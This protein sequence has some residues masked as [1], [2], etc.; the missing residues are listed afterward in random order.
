MNGRTFLKLGALCLLLTVVLSGLG[1]AQTR[2]L[3]VTDGDD[4]YTGVN[5]TNNPAGSGPKRTFEGAYAAF[6]S[7][8]T[9]RVA[10]GVYN[11]DQSG[12]GGGNDANG[13][14]LVGAKSMTFIIES[15]NLGNAVNLGGAGTFV[16]DVG[17]GNT[18][19][20]TP[21][22]PGTNTLGLGSAVAGITLTSG[23]MDVTGFGTTGFTVPATATAITRTGGA[24]T[25]TPSYAG[26][27]YTVLYNGA[28][29][30]TAGGEIPPT[31]ST[32]TL[33]K[34]SGSI[35]FNN[36][37]TFS[38]SGGGLSGTTAFSATFNGQVTLTTA[39]AAASATIVKGAATGAST[40]SFVGG[41]RVVSRAA[42]NGTPVSNASS[43]TLSV[44]GAVSI[45]QASTGAFADAVH[46]SLF[47]NSSTGTLSLT[48]GI[49]E[50]STTSPPY[51]TAAP[52]VLNVENTSTGTL[53][54]GG[55]SATTV[56]GFLT[57]SGGGT[58][59]IA[60]AVTV[61]GVLTNSA[62][63]ILALGTNT[64][65]LSGAGPHSNAGTI[66]S[67]GI[68]SGLLNF[69][70]T[71][72]KSMTGAGALPNVQNP[73]AGLLT[74][75]STTIVG[76]LSNTSSGGITAAS[77]TS[78]SGSIS[79]SGSGTITLAA[80]TT[81]GGA[82]TLGSSGGITFGA[83]TGLS[84][85]GA[86]S[87]TG[88]GTLTT[89]PG[90]LLAN[91]TVSISLGTFLMGGTVT[92][93]G[94]FTQTS[95]TLSFGIG[96]NLLDLKAD[97]MRVT[98]TVTSTDALPNGTPGSGTLRFSKGGSQ[99]FSGGANMT[100]WNFSVSAV[101]TGVTF[102]NGSIIVNRN[103]VIEANT[104]V[105][106]TTYNIR[107]VG[108][109]VGG[110]PP[111]FTHGGQY[112][113]TGGGGI[114]FENPDGGGGP[115]EIE[116]TIGGTGVYSNVEVRLADEYDFVNVAAGTIVTWSGRLTLTRGTI[117]TL[118]GTQL[119][120][121][122]FF[123]TP[124]IH[125]NLQDGPLAAIGDDDGAPDGKSIAVAGGLFNATGF[126]YHLEY[127]GALNAD[128]PVGTEF[129]S[130]ATT[131]VIDL[132]ISTTQGPGAG[133]PFGVDL[134]GAS[135]FRFSGNL[136]VVAGAILGMPVGFTSQ[137]ISNGSSVTH[138]VLGRIARGPGGTGVFRIDGTGVTINGPST[139]SV[140]PV[141]GVASGRITETLISLGASVTV[142][143][144]RHFTDGVTNLGTLNL[145]L[146]TI[147][148][149]AIDPGTTGTISAGTS[150]SGNAYTQ[151]STLNL[152]ANVTMAGPV[153]HSD[154]DINLFNY[155]LTAT[156]TSY[157]RAAVATAVY[158][159]APT[160]TTNGFLVLALTGAATF[161]FNGGTVPRL[162]VAASVTF[163]SSAEVTDR[164]RHTAGVVALATFNLT[165][166]GAVWSQEITGAV[167]TATTGNVAV[168]GPATTLSVGSAGVT[169]PNVTVA[170]TSATFTIVST[171]ATPTTLTISTLLT[172]TSGTIA[173]GSNDIA[174]TNAGNAYT[175]VAGSVT[176]TSSTALLTSIGEFVFGT[177]GQTITLTNSGLTIPNVRVVAGGVSFTPATGTTTMTITDRLTFGVGGTG[178]WGAIASTT[179][180]ASRLTV[181]SGAWI[182]RQGAG[183][184]S[185]APVFAGS[186]SLAY[187][188][189]GGYG[190][191]VEL[192]TSTTALLNLYISPAMSFPQGGAAPV[193]G[194]GGTITF[195]AAATATPVVVNGTLTLA[196][197]TL[198]Y[199]ATRP[200]QIAN[201]ATVR[202]E[203]NAVVGARGIISAGSANL[204][205]LGTY[206]L[207]YWCD[208][209][210]GGYASSGKEWIQGA[211][212]NL[213]VRMG[214]PIFAAAATNDVL[215]LHANRTV[216]NFT[217]NCGTGV[218]GLDL[219]DITDTF[220]S[221]LTVTGTTTLTMGTIYNGPVPQPPGVA[222][223]AAVLDVQG[224]VTI[225]AAAAFGPGSNLQF[226][227]TANQ[228]VTFPGP[229]VL[230]NVALNKTTGTSPVPSI[231]LIGPAAGSTVTVANIDFINGILI[232]GNNTVVLPTVVQ[233]FT[234][235]VAVGD[236]SHVVGNVRKNPGAFF[237]GRLEYPLGSAASPPRYRP[238]AIIFLLGNPLITAVGLTFSYVD[239]APA[240]PYLGF[241]IDAGSFIRLTGPA[242]FY[243]Q[244]LTTIGLNPSQTFD[245]ELTA[246]GYSTYT[247]GSFGINQLR[248][249]RRFGVNLNTNT[250]L[251]Q[252]GSNYSNFIADAQGTPTVR[253]IGSSGGIEPP[254]S[255]FTLG[256]GFITDVEIAKPG[257][258]SEYQLAQN[259]P[260]PFNPT[261]QINFDLPKQS[262]V[263]LEIYDMLGQ[264]VRTLING[265]TMEP[266]YYN[267]SWNGTNQ[268]G[269]TVS[270]GVY[271]YRIVA[272]KFMSLK[273]MMFM[274]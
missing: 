222:Y 111:S 242:P 266:G 91:N 32:L 253:V 49:T 247:S 271:F 201:G 189:T 171:G 144:I 195:T 212:A 101:G 198:A 164:Y 263:T 53:V 7:G 137:L 65:T 250:F 213:F 264:K 19:T 14:Q 66:T 146:A 163:A 27:T 224:N 121:S 8:T 89:N 172:H 183:M 1:L 178:S 45:E 55:S 105:I 18:V 207:G 188:E 56:N 162:N 116:A 119:N 142:S 221:M 177:A 48:G 160:T 138:S 206:N 184:L 84:V 30:Q 235:N 170:T 151:A 44:T 104:N 139:A 70:A 179:T 159:A 128:T 26:T 193:A 96:G 237:V 176:A 95:G 118:A 215:F 74:L 100:V 234:R 230:V 273:K 143:N 249:V 258:P 194:G 60:G 86:I 246:E 196:S 35:T 153:V 98:G 239:V 21:A 265:E 252:G 226:S 76:N 256:L 108:P 152:T 216:G 57:N 34:T 5:P 113:A 20:F 117:Q 33:S 127:L 31:V 24:L 261:T 124:S 155:N 236:A 9:V 63:G 2:Y 51:T 227:G 154:G 102:V 83:A 4:S 133:G 13:I 46:T 209:G 129:I 43:G 23:T 50:V 140:S 225:A 97:F 259:Y 248:I 210:L 64:L 134:A 190:T 59:T 251:L 272:D 214:T 39:T 197:G 254:G 109:I 29:T 126:S 11:V 79:N 223:P 262:A 94:N 82:V 67:A 199:G 92:V 68:G 73:A 187:T 175:Y 238:L 15:Y 231:T 203:S 125:R 93:F 220:G 77:V 211:V 107:M 232:T 72:A 165:I 255:Q 115:G 123:T 166:S 85:T 61:G 130:G 99:I 3:N 88:T 219:T 208:D 233:G 132:T 41:I 269:T 243:W 120:P 169:V 69:T 25:G 150:L 90:G 62:G 181:A 103:G 149:G 191:D 122:S 87:I 157:T 110:V 147:T 22:V 131:R 37:I 78:I 54:L 114:L 136:T 16:I 52:P 185:A 168:T 240:A 75:S 204:V 42:A 200:L 17:A 180:G 38:T 186:V 241:P 192:P 202:V 229:L 112:S 40:W 260:N 58:G 106:L 141:T 10:A 6:A 257:I 268:A 245:L 47:S 148:S 205:P 270:S 244:G 228:T 182:V 218:A 267:V 158:T 145:G 167:Y 81:V 174:F 274:K 12:I 135:P 173:L 217:L 28:G 161:D 80:V 36:A 156:G 71:V